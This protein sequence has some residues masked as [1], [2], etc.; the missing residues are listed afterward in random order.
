MIYF[1]QFGDDGP[2]KIGLTQQDPL[3]RVSSLQCGSPVKLHLL[4]TMDGK[5]E[6]EQELHQR[7]APYRMC[8]EWFKNVIPL[9]SYIDLAATKHIPFRYN[10]AWDL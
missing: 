5:Y 10:P 7:F 3:K 6:E 9:A 4:A 1:V 8:G 2:I